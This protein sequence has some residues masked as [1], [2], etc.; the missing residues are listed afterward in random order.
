MFSVFKKVEYVPE[1]M[2]LTS[3]LI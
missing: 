1:G 2:F 3:I